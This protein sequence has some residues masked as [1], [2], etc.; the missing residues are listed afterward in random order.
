MYSFNVKWQDTDGANFKSIFKLHLKS[1][2]KPAA[3]TVMISKQLLVNW[4]LQFLGCD[5]I[6][7]GCICRYCLQMG[8]QVYYV[9]PLCLKDELLSYQ[10]HF[11]PA[12]SSPSSHWPLIKMNRHGITMGT[13][14]AFSL[15]LYSCSALDHKINVCPLLNTESC[16]TKK[17]VMVR[18]QNMDSLSLFLKYR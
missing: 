4:G 13:P 9:L 14:C 18:C 2:V 8:L 16:L 11:H 3:I 7:C 15:L 1:L 10:R 12:H 6:I 17:L 5:L